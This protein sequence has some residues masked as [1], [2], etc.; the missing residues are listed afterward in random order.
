MSGSVI[1]AIIIY[2]GFVAIL[3]ALI[4]AFFPESFLPCRDDDRSRRCDFI[5]I[6]SVVFFQARCKLT[7]HRASLQLGSTLVALVRMSA[8]EALRSP[9]RVAKQA[10]ASQA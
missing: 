2:V 10:I 4:D 3:S 7:F 8:A 6:G 1:F 5:G 9:Q